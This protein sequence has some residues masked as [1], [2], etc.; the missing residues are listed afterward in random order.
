M[1]YHFEQQYKNLHK[2][3]V[4]EELIN[5][6][7][8]LRT[9]LFRYRSS[10]LTKKQFEEMKK[11]WPKEAIDFFKSKAIELAGNPQGVNNEIAY[12]AAISTLIEYVVPS[13]QKNAAKFIGE[14]ILK[15]RIACDI[16]LSM[17]LDVAFDA[18]P[19]HNNIRVI[20]GKRIEIKYT[21]SPSIFTINCE[22]EIDKADIFV[23]ALFNEEINKAILIGWKPQKDVRTFKRGNKATEKGCFWEEMSYFFG[24]NELAPISDLA[25]QFGVKELVEGTLLEQVTQLHCIPIPEIKLTTEMARKAVKDDFYEILG[26]TNPEVATTPVTTNLVSQVEKKETKETNSGDWNF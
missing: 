1:I 2:E 8:G 21:M 17:S 5:L 15:R 22:E 11:D 20:D 26:M 6:E 25:S 24:Y 19:S 4:S 14:D 18:G 3:K 13:R 16:A 12:R 10:S 23:F 7:R 9:G